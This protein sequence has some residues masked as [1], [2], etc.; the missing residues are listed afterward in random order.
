QR[1][2]ASTY[3]NRRGVRHAWLLEGRAWRREGSE[4]GPGSRRWPPPWSPAGCCCGRRLSPPDPRRIARRR[5]A[6]SARPGHRAIR[7]PAP[8]RH[9]VAAVA[10]DGYLPF[11][12]AWGHSPLTVDLVAGRRVRG[13]AIR[14]RPAIEYTVTVLAGEAP[15]AAAEVRVLAAATGE[16]ALLPLR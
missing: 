14:L 10:A 7:R 15:A 2:H 11:A 6:P 1:D 4:P 16:L 12:P 8:G 13:V 5:R 3:R 9:R